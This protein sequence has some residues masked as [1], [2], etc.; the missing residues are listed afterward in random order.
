MDEVVI[1]GRTIAY[2]RAGEGPAL[3]LVH[4][5]VCDSR[6]WQRQLEDLAEDYT[7]FAWDAPGCGASDDAPESFRL[8]DYAD[9]LAGFVT[10]VGIDS[11]H[12]L[13]HSFGAALVLE[14]HRRHPAVAASLV[15]AGGYAGWAGSLAPGEVRR[16]L[17]FALE[18]AAGLADGFDPHAVPGL[19][20]EN[21]SSDAVDLLATVMSEIRPAATRAMA[22]AL[23]DADLRDDLAGIEVPVLVLNGDADA[24]STPAV[25]AAL[26]T[27][28]R[29]SHLV[30]LE[31]LGH[32]AFL[33]APAR[34]D[35]A[36][37]SFL[38]SLA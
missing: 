4:G 30:M 24:R 38:G 19:F 10:E 6:V 22:H 7:V 36:I 2:Q 35:A 23:A 15:L 9:T 27:A 16:R 25:A 37:R 17:A 28:I 5:A 29:G 13:G 12:L 26:H 21:M 1:E 34:F 18:A 8:P 32:E 11:P 20:S 33:E 3:V 14:L 31:G